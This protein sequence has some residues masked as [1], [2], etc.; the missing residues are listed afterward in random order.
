MALTCP[1]SSKGLIWPLVEGYWDG[2]GTSS[3]L[4]GCWKQWG[5]CRVR[6]DCWHSQCTAGRV[7]ASLPTQGS[8]PRYQRLPPLPPHL[9]DLAPTAPGGGPGRHGYVE[10]PDPCKKP[11]HVDQTGGGGVRDRMCACDPPAGKTGR[12]NGVSSVSPGTL[13]QEGLREPGE[14]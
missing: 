13:L 8:C 12:P 2:L 14:L 3:K 6:A 9:A 5:H 7:L 10:G 11:G 1:Q 4:P